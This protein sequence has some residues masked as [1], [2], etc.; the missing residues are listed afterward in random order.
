TGFLIRPAWWRIIQ[1][2][3]P[4]WP[5]AVSPG[6]LCRKD[7]SVSEPA[8]SQRITRRNP[9]CIIFLLDHSYSMIEGLAGSKRPKREALATALNRIISDILQSCERGEEKPF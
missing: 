2:L 7:P 9:G 6:P 5:E 1:A 3:H 4:C 8:Y